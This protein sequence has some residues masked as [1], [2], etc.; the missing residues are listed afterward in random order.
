MPPTL[1]PMQNIMN[2]ST[3]RNGNRLTISFTRPL[4][5][6]D[7]SGRDE[8]L[9]VCRNV[10]WAFGGTTTFDNGN[11][12]ALN[13]HSNR[14]IF[15]NQLCLCTT[16]PSASPTPIVISTEILTPTATPAE[17]PTSAATSLANVVHVVIT[18]I[19]I[20]IATIF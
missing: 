2:I 15:A 1:D 8:N 6:P 19:F 11:V 9:D 18:F 20:V 17:T 5:S 4:V 14:G 13:F 12:T 3:T 7:T 10:L 16:T